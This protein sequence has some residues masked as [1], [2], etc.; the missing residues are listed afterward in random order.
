MICWL[1]GAFIDLD[2]ARIDPRDRGFLLGDG[3]FETLLAENGAVRRPARHFARLR[4]AAQML[5]IPLKFPDA[6]MLEVMRRLLRENQ[7]L[8]GRAAIRTTLSR[9]VSGRGLPPPPI[10]APTLLM[11]VTETPPPPAFMRAVTVSCI[12]N[13]KSISSRI[14]S[15][16][17][18]DNV[19]ARKEAALR[20]ADEALMPN[21]S[22]AIAC[23]SAANLFI[24]LDGRLLTPSISS[25]ALP[26]IMRGLVLEAAAALAIPAREACIEP[27]DLQRASEAFLSNALNGLCPLVEID[28]RPL[29]NRGAG[30]LTQRLQGVIAN[31]E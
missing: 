22:G 21:S 29:G 12:R 28:G 10:A 8:P 2:G 7:L 17:Y 16:N 1:N 30:P 24:V 9:G 31:R 5:D 13:E 23:A 14:K 6:E 18:L 3:V 15:L 19:M 4:A 26:G 11:T 27:G 25:G 20:G